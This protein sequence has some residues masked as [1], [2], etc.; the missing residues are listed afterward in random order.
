MW[1]GMQIDQS[2]KQF[3]NTESS[4]VESVETNEPDWQIRSTHGGMENDESD[5]QYEN[6]PFS[7]H[8]SLEPA[9]N[10]TFERR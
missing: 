3:E 10:T 7:I 9:S 8:A 6:A 1:Q 4:I 5:E 2:D